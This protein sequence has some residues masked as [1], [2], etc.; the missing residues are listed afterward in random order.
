MIYKKD[1]LH[2][3]VG[4]QECKVGLIQESLSMKTDYTEPYQQKKIDAE[5]SIVCEVK[6][7]ESRKCVRT[8][9]MTKQN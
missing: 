9:L 7:I 1:N 8:A 2:N 4:F 6:H 5:E 3:E